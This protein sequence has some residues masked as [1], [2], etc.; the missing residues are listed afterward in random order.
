MLTAQ[1]DVILDCTE[2]TDYQASAWADFI[3]QRSMAGPREASVKAQQ[4][5][6]AL[7]QH[8]SD[9]R[10]LPAATM[11]PE[12][13]EL[14]SWHWRSTRS[15]IFSES[16]HSA[17]APY[18]LATAARLAAACARLC[19]RTTILP[20]PDA[21]VAVALCEEALLAHGWLMELWPPWK[22]ALSEGESLDAALSGFHAALRKAAAEAAGAHAGRREE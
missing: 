22:E 11:H 5:Q 14:L 1:F 4:A 20:Y 10:H 19:H 6:Q 16:E 17:S 3:L 13:M 12:A 21:V 7:Q 2:S 15:I 18:N 8:I 9:C